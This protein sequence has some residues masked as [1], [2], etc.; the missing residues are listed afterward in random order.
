MGK[1]YSPVKTIRKNK[2]SL[3]TLYDFCTLWYMYLVV[4]QHLVDDLRP[5]QM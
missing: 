1:I 5:F 3:Y 2:Q 4:H